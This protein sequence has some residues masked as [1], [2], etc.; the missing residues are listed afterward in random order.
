MPD[1]VNWLNGFMERLRL[2]PVDKSG[3]GAS[4]AGTLNPEHLNLVLY[5]SDFGAP[6]ENV[7][8]QNVKRAQLKP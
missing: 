8:K 1:F 7:F 5:F 4:Q 6:G 3:S 2:N